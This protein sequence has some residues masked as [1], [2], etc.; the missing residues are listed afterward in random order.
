VTDVLAGRLAGVTVI[1]FANKPGKA[2]DLTRAGA[3]AVTNRLSQIR[4][5]LRAAPRP[6][7]PN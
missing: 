1:G 3:D 5:P 6:A 4:A 2:D 7:L